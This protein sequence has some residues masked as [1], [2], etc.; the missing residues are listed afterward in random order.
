M[1][2]IAST[3]RNS[4]VAPART[5]S[6]LF[7]VLL[8]L[9]G[10]GAPAQSSQ[11]AG[12]QAGAGPVGTWRGQSKCIVKPSACHDEDAVYRISAAQSPDRVQVSANKVVDGKEVNMGSSD[13]AY[14]AHSGSIDCPLPAGT[15]VHL[16]FNGSAMEGRMTLKDGT[17]WRKISLRRDE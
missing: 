13:C 8:I 7:A 15:A 14:D 9:A 17:L 12:K 4:N 5:G 2:S 11:A 6:S 1:P 3:S 10:L 16:E